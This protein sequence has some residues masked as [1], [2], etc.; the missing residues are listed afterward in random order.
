[1]FLPTRQGL[2][3]GTDA[4]GDRVAIT[5]RLGCLNRIGPRLVPGVKYERLLT[6][7]R[8]SS[9]LEQRDL[10]LGVSQLLYQF[11]ALEMHQVEPAP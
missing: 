6:S 2:G 1:M 10:G 8:R 9:A 3:I 7:A 11:V 5:I 4:T